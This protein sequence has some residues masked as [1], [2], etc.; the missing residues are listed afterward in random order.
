MSGLNNSF[1]TGVASWWTVAPP[2]PSKRE[3]TSLDSSTY[4]PQL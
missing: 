4:E 1:L 2:F 3:R